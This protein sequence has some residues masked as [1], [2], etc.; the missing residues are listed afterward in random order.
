MH[1]QRLALRWHYTCYRLWMWW[2][3]ADKVSLER[4]CAAVLAF[5]IDYYL[6]QYKIKHGRGIHVNVI[7][8]NGEEF[9]QVLHRCVT[10]VKNRDSLPIEVHRGE[11][12]RTT[13]T[14]DEYLTNEDRYPL[15]IE[16]YV[17]EVRRLFGQLQAAFVAL[18]HGE[19]HRL[20]RGYSRKLIHIY[21]DLLNVWEALIAL[22]VSNDG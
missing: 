10:A 14:L 19:D 8:H 2:S 16:G 5:P 18:Q 1:W 15:S 21:G 4:R 7:Q 6:P 20:Y 11:V 3:G 12:M 9:T 13:K 17:K 22:A